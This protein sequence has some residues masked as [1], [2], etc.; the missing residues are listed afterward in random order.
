[1]AVSFIIMIVSSLLIGR[2]VK[3]WKDRS[4]VLWGFLN[5]MIEIL[6]YV[7]FYLRTYNPIDFATP[8]R[9]IALGIQAVIPGSAIMLIIV[10]IFL[11]KKTD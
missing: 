10:A 2:I 11:K 7:I 4:W 1:M 5:L 3:N 8:I 9:W 6:I